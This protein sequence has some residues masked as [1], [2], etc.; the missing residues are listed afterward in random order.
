MVRSPV[1]CYRKIAGLTLIEVLIALAI[2]A[3]ALTAVIKATSQ[4]IRGTT[5]LQ[6]KTIAM[7]VGQ[8]VLNEARLNLLPLSTT[9]TSQSTL[10][11]NQTWYWQATKESTPNKRIKKIS[12]RVYTHEADDDATPIIQLE[13]YVYHGE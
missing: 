11:L 13:T 3:I 8:N 1:N 5:H 6:T 9:P 4:T 10:M 12:V 7:W 2:I